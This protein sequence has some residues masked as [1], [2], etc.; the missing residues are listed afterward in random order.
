[1]AVSLKFRKS[2]RLSSLKEIQTLFS[3]GSSFH[4]FPFRVVW[5]YAKTAPGAPARMV[6]SV[7]KKKFK[8]AVHRNLIRRRI[9]E[10]YRQQKEELYLSLEQNQRPLVFMLMYTHSEILSFAELEGKI[11]SLFQRFKKE[12]DAH[13]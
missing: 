5:N 1:M 2:E 3:E 8:R 7:P 10:A 13:K 9:R 11:R 12:L 4:S 6:I